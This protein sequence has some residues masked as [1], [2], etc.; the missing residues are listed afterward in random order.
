M[1]RKKYFPPI[2]ILT[3]VCCFWWALAA[4]IGYLM[5]PEMTY[6]EAFLNSLSTFIFEF[7][8]K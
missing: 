1:K 6:M 3:M 2:L 7:E 5:C 4:F 8:C